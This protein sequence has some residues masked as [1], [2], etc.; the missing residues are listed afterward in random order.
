[1]HRSVFKTDLHLKVSAIRNCLFWKL[2]YTIQVIFVDLTSL[3]SH[4]FLIYSVAISKLWQSVAENRGARPSINSGKTNCI[5]SCSASITE[6]Q[7][8]AVQFPK[9]FSQKRI[10]LAYSSSSILEKALARNTSMQFTRI[11]VPVNSRQ[12]FVTGFFI[13]SKADCRSCK[14]SL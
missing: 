7:I 12:C 14:T 9:R 11:N 3:I 6:T 4:S 2:H 5:L 10:L 8:S 1:M 13:L